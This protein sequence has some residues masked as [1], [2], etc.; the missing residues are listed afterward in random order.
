MP[1][2]SNYYDSED[3]RTRTIGIESSRPAVRRTTGLEGSGCERV[4]VRST[5]SPRHGQME[6]SRPSL[7][8]VLFGA[9]KPGSRPHHWQFTTV[10][11]TVSAA[12]GLPPNP[13]TANR[14]MS[15][16]YT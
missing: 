2:T 15:S 3:A 10:P 4:N 13:P 8:V 16:E 1:G 7:N 11:A 9:A 14:F 12:S 6:Y 5:R